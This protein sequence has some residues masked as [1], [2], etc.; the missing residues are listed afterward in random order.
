MEEGLVHELPRLY[1]LPRGWEEHL[2][3]EEGAEGVLGVLV[4]HQVLE[5]EA[6]LVPR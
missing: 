1:E 6:S 5:E 4:V 3:V 2:T